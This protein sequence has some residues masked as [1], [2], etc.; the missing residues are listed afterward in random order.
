MQDL[1]HGL[2]K[3]NIKTSLDQATALH[4]L[5]TQLDTDPNL[6]LQEFSDLL[7]NA[8]ETFTANLGA[9]KATDKNEE[10][11]LLKTL[12]DSAGPRTLDLA[13]LEPESLEKLRLRNKWRSVLQK[14]LQ[15]IT[16]DLLTLDEDKSYLAEPR[17]LMRVLDHRMKTTTNMQ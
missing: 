3:I 16:K 13:S 17:D 4:S 8:D 1:F 2:N 9:I 5:A 7:F 14:N 10:D 11:E 15:N 12:R 6:S